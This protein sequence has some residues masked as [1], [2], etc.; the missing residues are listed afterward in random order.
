MGREVE[1]KFL[2]ATDAWRRAAERS[3]RMSQGYLANCGNVS[4]RVRI[5]GTQAQLNIKAGGLVAA[6]DEFEYPIPVDDA[7][8]LLTRL[9]RRPLIEK[10]RHFVPYRGFEWEID[11]FE[12]RNEGLCVAEIELEHEEQSFPKPP[13]LGP[14]VTH[15][16]RYYNVKLIEYPYRDW[17]DAER[18]V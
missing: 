9:C 3:Q 17:T 18:S 5:A 13:W 15:L 12:G 1:R 6:R 4:V 14:E 7:R 16:P 10:T 11:E 8:E 2:P